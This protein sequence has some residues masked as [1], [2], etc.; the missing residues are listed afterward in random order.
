M[1]TTTLDAN[2]VLDAARQGDLPSDTAVGAKFVPA[3]LSTGKRTVLQFFRTPQLLVTGTV[4]GALF[5]IEL[6]EHGHLP[7]QLLAL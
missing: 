5:L 3:T 2:G 4:Q 7:L 1:S 6:S